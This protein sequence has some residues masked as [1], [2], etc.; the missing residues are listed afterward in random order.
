MTIEISD[1]QI[2]EHFEKQQN[3]DYGGTFNLLEPYVL[4]NLSS[5]TLCPKCLQPHGKMRLL[6]GDW[7]EQQC[8]CEKKDESKWGDGRD[9]NTGYETCYCCGLEVITSGSRWSSFYCQDCKKA[10]RKFNDSVGTCVIPLGR[11]S[12]MNGIGFKKSAP[13]QE[14]TSLFSN[15]LKSMG[16]LMGRA[17][18]HGALVL[19]HQLKILKLPEDPNLMNLTRASL[20]ANR[21]WDKK[22]ALL[23][24]ISHILKSPPK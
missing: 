13:L 15:E 10:I 11:H 24:L 4:E 3:T 12:I 21:K 16:E 19:R 7:V 1:E 23:S 18:E 6:Y 14:A 22:D 17:H 9:F 8:E 5:L 20:D 2:R